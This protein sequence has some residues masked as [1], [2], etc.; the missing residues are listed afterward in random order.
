MRRLGRAWRLL[1]HSLSPSSA[2]D[3]MMLTLILKGGAV[4]FSYS[5]YPLRRKVPCAIGDER[6][7]NCLSWSQKETTESMGEHFHKEA[8]S[9][10]CARASHDIVELA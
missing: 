9:A 2:G 10:W 8:E 6:A 3:K 1:W 5:R 4:Y 7:V